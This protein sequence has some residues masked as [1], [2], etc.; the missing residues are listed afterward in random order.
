MKNATFLLLLLAACT[1]SKSTNT[2]NPFN[3]KVV[4]CGNFIVYQLSGDNKEFISIALNA[5]EVELKANLGFV[6]GRSEG[7][8]VKWK[9]FSGDISN[10]L[11]NDAVGNRPERV[12]ELTA[13][14]GT[15]NV[16]I[17]KDL[18]EQA[19]NGDPYKV[20]LILKNVVF[21]GLVV[22]YIE[23]KDVQVGWIPG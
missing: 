14:G 8:E 22:D 11:C 17:E 2:V 1:V 7:I 3:G 13:S 18:L 20:S 10:V 15:L 4:G 16:S 9:K 19:K 6:I 12:H 21:E 5:K 23:I